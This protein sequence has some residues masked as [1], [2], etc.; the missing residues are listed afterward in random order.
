MSADTPLSLQSRLKKINLVVLGWSIGLLSLM[1]WV[2]S[3]GLLLQEH[4]GSGRELLGLL[5]ENLVAPM[6]F[7]DARATEDALATLRISPNTCSAE[8]FDNDGRTVARYHSADRPCT[9]D[10]AQVPADGYAFAWPHLVFATTAHHDNRSI[11]RIALVMDLAPLR[12]QLAT[13]FGFTA[14]AIGLAL[15]LALR[16]QSRLVTA[17]TRPLAQLTGLMGRVSDGQL[18]IH[19]HESGIAELDV[20]GRG[21]NS[22]IAEIRDR[23]MRLAANVVNLEQQVEKRTSELR[24]AK[25]AAEAGSRAKSEFLATMSHEIRTPMNGVLGMTEL[26]LK[27]HLEPGQRRFVEAVEVSGRH[28][29]SVINDIL[30]FSKIESGRLELEATD[31]ALASL[32]EK[33]AEMFAQP[34]QAKGLEFRVELPP[35]PGPI[36]RGD[37]LRLRQIL[38]NLLNNAIKFT[39]R[40]EIVIRLSIRSEDSG[41]VDFDLSVRDTGIGISPA[42]HHRVFDHFSQADGSTTRK[43]GGTGLGLAICRHLAR[44]MGGEIALESEPGRGSVFHLALG[45]PRGEEA[46][47]PATSAPDGKDVVHEPAC[48]LKGR[49][50]L[51]EDNPVNQIMALAWLESL[52]VEA[53][54][55]DNGREVLAQVGGRDFDLILMDCQMPEMDGFDATAAIRRMEEAGHRHTPIVALTAN[56]VTGDRERCLAA[57]MDD[58]LAKPYSGEQLAAVLT[59]WLPADG[60]LPGPLPPPE[61]PPA[62]VAPPAGLPAINAATLEKVRAIMPT[63]GDRLLRRLAEAWLQSAPGGLEKLRQALAA[64]DP[65]GL[66]QASHALKSGSANIGAE[67]LSQM[68][69]DIEHLARD[70]QVDG[71][72]V[73]AAGLEFERVRGELQRILEGLAA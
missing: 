51:A 57:G 41:R 17:V 31:V 60:A 1:L 34:A 5:H 13:Q 16:F 32:I 55:A 2:I 8:V 20:L 46:R 28:L 27:T 66:A 24:H 59:R 40:G 72:G 43:Y 44:Q 50:L 49:V 21:F 58:Y 62:P 9:F 47:L 68:L 54:V 39:E 69:R 42:V 71:A 61:A 63:G 7:Q 3:A 11:G 19:A 36:V 35:C 4:I 52:G 25:E 30:D 56:A 73:T 65:G 12:R 48:A 14:L 70:G 33:T 10:A 29:L 26:L 64:N 37:P 23:D 67:Q 45:L 15:A 6:T 53:D 22:M 18:D 38:A